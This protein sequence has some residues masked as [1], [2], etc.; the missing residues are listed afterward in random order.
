MLKEISKRLT[1]KKSFFVT[2]LE[3]FFNA[4]TQ[5]YQELI[6]QKEVENSLLEEKIQKL[7]QDIE[8]LVEIRRQLTDQL[9]DRE[10][11]IEKLEAEKAADH[12]S[13]AHYKKLLEENLALKKRLENR[14]DEESD[15]LKAEIERLRKIIAGGGKT[16]QDT[17]TEQERNALIEEISKS[18]KS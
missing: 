12:S 17:L 4:I 13:D 3:G 14:S 7:E 9:G 8:N 1:M 6:H 18:L 15:K 5:E 2:Q 11:Y 10:R 16:Y